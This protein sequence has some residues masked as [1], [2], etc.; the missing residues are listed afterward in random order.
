MLD[1]S[2]LKDE[3]RAAGLFERREKETWFKAVLMMSAV[4]TIFAIQ[5]TGPMWL[6]LVLMP[7]AALFGTGFVMIGHEGCHRGLSSNPKRNALIANWCFPLFSGLSAQY[8]SHKHNILHH[9]YPN[10]HLDDPD[11]DLWP[12]ASTK[13]AYLASGPLRRWFQRNLQGYCFWPLTSFM[14]WTMRFHSVV[15]SYRY[16]KKRGANRRW[17]T[18]VGCMAGHYTCWVI[19]PSILFGWKAIGFY[20][21]FWAIM[22]MYLAGVF[23]PAHIGLPILT[24]H[25]DIWR[26]QF[27]TTRNLRLP[28]WLSVFFI[29]LDYQLEHHL[30]PKISHLHL[31]EVAKITERWA[32]ANGLPYHTVGYW[33]GI[34]DATRFIR[35]G[36]QYEPLDHVGPLSPEAVSDDELLASASPG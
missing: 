3:L 25:D 18:D 9:A 13:D 24:G 14:V 27:E 11:V 2:T 6:A 31:P 4:L 23:A 32:K 29:G 33:E 7:I 28:K 20:L 15:F 19:V 30:F 35:D 22:S 12:M 10:V 1:M 5:M 21:L 36:W 26:L 16:F 34:C 17:A 8:W